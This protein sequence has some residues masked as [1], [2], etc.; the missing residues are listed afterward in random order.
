MNR[1]PVPQML[2]V[3]PQG[4]FERAMTFGQS[5]P[6]TL[7][8]IAYRKLKRR[9]G[10]RSPDYYESFIADL[11][12][13][14][15]CIDLGANVGEFTSRFP[16]KGADVIGFEPD[17]ETFARLSAATA[18]YDTVTLHQK[19]TGAQADTLMLRRSAKYAADPVRY[20]VAA[21][22][23]RDDH[24]IDADNGVMVEVVDFTAFLTELDRDVR[25]L[26]I[27]IEGSEWDLLE[28]LMAAPVSK[29]IDSIFVET[30]ERFDP[31]VI[32]PRA[33]ALHRLA[34]NTARPYIDL[35]WGR[36][37]RPQAQLSEVSN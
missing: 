3:A 22:L 6:G 1:R 14:D 19:A 29:R 5:L 34:E 17:P 20:S 12:P 18:P 23:V 35:Y 37:N 30:H 32:I 16:A 31:S 9:R 27:D 11:R 7:G 4:V 10:L 25:I 2:P 21:S 24:K 28:A 15:L 26:K 36:H 8:H 13:G 33:N